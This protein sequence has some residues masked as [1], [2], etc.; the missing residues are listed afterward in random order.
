V[1]VKPRVWRDANAGGWC[2]Q[3]PGGVPVRADSW[4]SAV[5]CVLPVRQEPRA[6][7]DEFWAHRESAGGSWRR[8][9]LS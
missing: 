8:L 5:A 2:Y 1:S 3:L 9:G 7:P 6:N 4:A